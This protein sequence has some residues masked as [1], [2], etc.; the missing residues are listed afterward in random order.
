MFRLTPKMTRVVKSTGVST[1]DLSLSRPAKRATL[2]SSVIAPGADGFST[3]S[4][5]CLIRS[6]TAI[7]KIDNYK[8]IEL[9]KLF[10]MMKEYQ[11]I[12]MKQR[13]KELLVD[14]YVI[15][16]PCTS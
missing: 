4:L 3:T 2:S 11:R 7:L 1:A 14:L 16:L 15:D 12:C 8:E 6:E 13:Y 10:E 5:I 9:M